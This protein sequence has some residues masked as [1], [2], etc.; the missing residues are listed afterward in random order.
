MKRLS[1]KEIEAIRER[2]E[3]ATDGPWIYVPIS[4]RLEYFI[5]G[6]GGNEAIAVEVFT[7][8]DATFIAHA[9]TDI[10]KL[11]AEIERLRGKL[12]EA[13]SLLYDAQ[14]L[15]GNVHCYG[16]EEYRGISE[17]FEGRDNE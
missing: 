2:V 4:D 5:G 12:D 14:S 11:L 3:K 6:E 15:M 7:K 13:N 10:P 8:E 1:S 16:T 17:Y 9:R